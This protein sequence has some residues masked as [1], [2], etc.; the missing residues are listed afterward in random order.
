MSSNSH[1]PHITPTST[2]FKVA[3]VLFLLT[4]LTVTAHHYKDFLGV[5]AGPV[6]F[7]IALIKAI[8][9]IL[10]FMHLKDDTNMN[11]VIF[12]TGFLALLLLFLFSYGDI[13]TR[14]HEVSPL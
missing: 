4:I 8:F 12:G 2:Y 3:M 7:I 13:I 9:V 1:G 6:A 5:L 10:W 14:V 11:R